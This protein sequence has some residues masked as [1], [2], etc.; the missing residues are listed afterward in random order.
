MPRSQASVAVLAVI[1][2]RIGSTRLP[3]KVLLKL[4]GKP[5]VAYAIESAKSSNRLA[6]VI[7]ATD[8]ERVKAVVEGYDTECWLTP[9]ELASGTDRVAWTARKLP[10]YEIV[11]NIQADE[12]F[13]SPRDIDLLVD[14]M[15]WRKEVHIATLAIISSS[16][17]EFHSPD[18]VKLVM[19]ADNHA[20][21][22]SRSPIPYGSESFLK[23]IGIYAY[24]RE[25]LLRLA[26]TPPSPLERIERL[27]QLRALQLGY[28]IAVGL[29]EE[30]RPF[31]SV[32]TAEELEEAERL[33][34]GKSS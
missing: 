13:L 7:V 22:F 6:R 20:L 9:P 14:T 27:E 21:Y 25:A 26:D 16:E 28:N 29:I 30:R 1:P 32:D 23:H 10:Q 3:E 11:L 24:R 12:P 31:I 4:C 19:N 15:L 34:C 5:L 33:L 18:V 2:A 17:R 8:A